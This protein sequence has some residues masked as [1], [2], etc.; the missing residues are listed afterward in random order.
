MVIPA[1]VILT[2]HICSVIHDVTSASYSL[3]YFGLGKKSLLRFITNLRSAQSRRHRRAFG[4]LVPPNKTPSPP[5]LNYEA[6]QIGRVF[7][8]FQNVKTP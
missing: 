4:G 2:R 1:A 8:K 5:K 6:Q 3:R 7:I